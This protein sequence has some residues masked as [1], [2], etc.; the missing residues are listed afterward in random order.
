MRPDNW[1]SKILHFSTS[2]LVSFIFIKSRHFTEAYLDFLHKTSH[3]SCVLFFWFPCAS[4]RERAHLFLRGKIV[5][6]ITTTLILWSQMKHSGGGLLRRVLLRGSIVTWSSSEVLLEEASPAFV[7]GACSSNGYKSFARILWNH[8]RTDRRRSFTWRGI[9]STVNSSH[10]SHFIFCGTSSMWSLYPHSATQFENGL[11]L[12]M[13]WRRCSID[14]FQP[15][16]VPIDHIGW[17]CSRGYVILWRDFVP[18][19]CFWYSTLF[20]DGDPFYSSVTSL[21]DA[22]TRG[23]VCT[24]ESKSN[25]PLI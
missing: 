18:V 8:V 15:Y 14:F 7:L 23:N 20:S 3:T 24:A 22:V 17:C 16:A 10:T 6:G 12:I 25:S 1:I 11:L 2:N 13:W 19:Y 21:D 4:S 9:S 5:R